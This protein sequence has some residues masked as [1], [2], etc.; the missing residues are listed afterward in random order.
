MLVGVDSV[1]RYL[2]KLTWPRAKTKKKLLQSNY[3]H[4]IESQL[5]DTCSLFTYMHRGYKYQV[6]M[7]K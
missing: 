1:V 4:V 3:K 2:N 5:S 7:Q 6:K